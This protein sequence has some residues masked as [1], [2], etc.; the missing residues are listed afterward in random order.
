MAT[1]PDSM[2]RSMGSQAFVEFLENEAKDFILFKTGLLTAESQNDPI[3]RTRV[4]RDIIE[5]IALIPDQIKRAHYIRECS[6][7]LNVEEGILI[8]EVNKTLRANLKKSQF[9]RRPSEVRTDFREMERDTSQAP[10]QQKATTDPYTDEY[11]E[12]AVIRNII[13]YGHCNYDDENNITMASFILASIDDVSDSFSNPLYAKIIATV[14]EVMQTE[15]PL[16][17]EFW[18]QH[19]DPEIVE[20]AVSFLMPE[21]EYSENWVK[22]KDMPLNTQKAPEENYVKDSIDSILRFKLKK[23]D[24]QILENQTQIETLAATSDADPDKVAL[25]LK[26]HKNLKQTKSSVEE[27][28]K[29]IGIRL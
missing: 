19:A 24:R 13:Q 15:D 14:Q 4:T 29:T 5:S 28:L 3:A 1:D 23:I 26:I 7:E 25:Q 10:I 12:R 2:V 16:T 20:L 17:Q 21:Y 11:Q 8:E 6:I 9:Q 22:K 27:Q 18:T